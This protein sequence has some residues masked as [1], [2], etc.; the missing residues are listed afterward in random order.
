[1]N[2]TVVCDKPGSPL[3]LPA[4]PNLLEPFPPVDDPDPPCVSPVSGFKSS[5]KKLLEKWW[6]TEWTMDQLD[7]AVREFPQSMLRLTSPVIMF[8]RHNNE[9]E[10]LRP[11]RKIFPGVAENVLD[12]ICSVLIAHNHVASL[13]D[14]QPKTIHHHFAGSDPARLE[15]VPEKARTTLGI[16]FLNA[17]PQQVRDRILNS[18]SAE[19]HKDLDGILDK[20][21]FAISGRSDPTLKSAVI[22][23]TDVLETQAR[24]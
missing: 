2:S 21:L 3:K 10:L 9:K 5:E 7:Q 12:C 23:L 18:R 13:A 15:I 24:R 16:Q 19:L 11:F 6:D 22:V 14:S 4:S 8:L 1:M 17:S 20:L